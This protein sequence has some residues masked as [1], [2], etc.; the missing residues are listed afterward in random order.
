MRRIE[1]LVGALAV[2]GCASGAARADTT[3]AIQS[4]GAP[5]GASTQPGGWSQSGWQPGAATPLAKTS[6]KQAVIGKTLPQ[7][8]LNPDYTVNDWRGWGLATPAQ[9]TRWVRYYDDAVLIDDNGKVLNARYGVDWGGGPRMAGYAAQPA[10]IPNFSVNTT[11]RV[12]TVQKDANTIVTTSVVD[13]P[14]ALPAAGYAGSGDG[15]GYAGYAGGMRVVGYTPGTITT[16]TTTHTIPGTPAR[17]VKVSPM[18]RKAP[19]HARRPSC[20]IDK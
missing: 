2:L 18:R 20:P 1:L 15:A 6:Y 14:P 3:T 11:P 16:V 4:A 17:I 7:V 13:V 10:A 8:W 12:T 19:R 5:V 9:G